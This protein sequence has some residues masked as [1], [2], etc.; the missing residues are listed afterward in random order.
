MLDPNLYTSRRE[1]VAL[2]THREL[3]LDDHN[4]DENVNLRRELHQPEKFGALLRPEPEKG[5]VAL[6]SRSVPQWNPEKGLYEWWYWGG[7]EVDPYGPYK[8]TMFQLTHYA[9]STDGLRWEKPDLKRFDWRDGAAPNIAYDPEEGHRALYHVLRDEAEANPARRYKG[10]LGQQGRKLVTSPDGFAW[11][12]V[13]TEPLAS[14]DESHFCYDPFG[15][16]YLA[17]L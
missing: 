3:F 4:V 8:S 13:E 10:M 17:M 12:P 14:S 6:Q 9:T 7:W 1:P 2:G 11:S 16:R 5:L 15:K